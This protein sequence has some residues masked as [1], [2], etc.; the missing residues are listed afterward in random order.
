M[1]EFQMIQTNM[2]FLQK[3]TTEYKIQLQGVA[4]YC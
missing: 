2:F 1:V 3:F 4:D